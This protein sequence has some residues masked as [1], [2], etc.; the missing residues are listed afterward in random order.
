MAESS[1]KITKWLWSGLQ[2]GQ[3]GNAY[4]EN[5]LG[6]MYENGWGVERISAAVDWYRKSAAQGNDF[7]ENNLGRAYENGWT[8]ETS[9][10]EARA[11]YRKSA[12]QGNSFAQN[13]L[14]RLSENG[15]GVAKDNGQAIVWYSQSAAQG[16]E[17]GEENLA[18]VTA[19]APMYP[20]RIYPAVQTGN[21][22]QNIVVRWPSL[23]N[24]TYQ[25]VGTADLSLPFSKW[26]NVG[27][28]VKATGT[29]TSVSLPITSLSG[30]FGVKC[31]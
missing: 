19:S 15:W 4:G 7:G 13:N 18:R 8:G 21:T 20:T 2:I 17:F 23:P 16:N 11:W 5:N 22:G 24:Q 29:T 27:S 6:R 28:P 25:I 26:T 14:G 10:A 3:P 9:Y 30:F 12:A 1:A 31:P